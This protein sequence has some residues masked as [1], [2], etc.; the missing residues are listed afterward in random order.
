MGRI[1][2]GSHQRF[3]GFDIT[4]HRGLNQCSPIV[5]PPVLG[6]G[7]IEEERLVYRGTLCVCVRITHV[8]HLLLTLYR[9]SMPALMSALNL[10][11]SG[12]DNPHPPPLKHIL[13]SASSSKPDLLAFARL[14]RPQTF[15]I[16][17]LGEQQTWAREH[18]RK[19]G[20]GRDGE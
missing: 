4:F 7:E 5:E 9:M 13:N 2:V 11:M 14:L 10:F 20:R 12:S 16:V 1:R 8:L 6:G 18:R 3:H 19:E 17:G 15:P